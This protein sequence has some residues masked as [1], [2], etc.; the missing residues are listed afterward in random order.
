MIEVKNLIKDY[1]NN[2]AVKNI[3]FTINDG[4]IVGFLG[5]NGAGK[6]T[7]MNIITG[8]L[9]ATSGSVN[10]NGYDILEQPEEAKRHIGYLPEQPPLYLDMTVK[11][12]L[13]FV[14][15]LKKTKLP[16][17]PHLKEIVQLV[18]IGHVYNRLIRNLSKGYRQRVGIAQA[19]IGNPDVLILDEPTVGLD[20]QQIIEIRNLISQ[21]GRN[22]TVILSSHI[23]S[24][25][26]AV[27]ERVII[28]NQ[29]YQIANE[30]A[31]ELSARL[32]DDH[33]VMVRMI[34]P[35]REAKA[36]LES[37]PGVAG[38]QVVG[39]HQNA[40]EFKVE[41]GAERDIALKIGER[42]VAKR[43]PITSMYSQELTLEDIYIRMVQQDPAQL[44]INASN[45]ET[46]EENEVAEATLEP[47]V[48]LE[49]ASAEQE[50]QE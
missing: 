18:K 17:G 7:T 37:I 5:P 6:S 34:A 24:E 23:L 11:E 15:D 45:D 2:R 49:D 8:Y 36:M 1:G 3:S 25:I 29:G 12:Y 46:A 43:W 47:T 38:V 31:G 19:L 40:T 9:S 48:K 26:Q 32:S 50:V 10:V 27:C 30:T 21:L 13:N 44:D 35:P 28:I 22:H 41:P 16:R 33:S 4:E 20:P 39:L 42:A 14:Y